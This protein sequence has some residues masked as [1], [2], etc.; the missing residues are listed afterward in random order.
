MPCTYLEHEC[1]RP[2][3][4]D[5]GQGVVTIIT[6]C[7]AIFQL[8][9]VE[10]T[11]T[12]LQPAIQVPWNCIRQSVLN[13]QATSSIAE[14]ISPIAVQVY[15]VV[16]N[17]D[18]LQPLGPCGEG[19]ATLYA[20][21]LDAAAPVQAWI[22]VWGSVA[23]TVV[24]KALPNTQIRVDRAVNWNFGSG[25]AAFAKVLYPGDPT[26]CTVPPIDTV[27]CGPCCPPATPQCPV[28]PT[29]CS[30]DDRL[31]SLV[32]CPQT[33]LPA[34]IQYCGCPEA[35]IR[36]HVRYPP[37]QLSAINGIDTLSRPA[38]SNGGS[39][40]LNCVP[41]GSMPAAS[42]NRRVGVIP[43]AFPVPPDAVSLVLQPAIP[44][45]NSDLLPANGDTLVI[46]LST[47]RCYTPTALPPGVVIDVVGPQ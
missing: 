36:T 35:P 6:G 20:V 21:P 40:D 2:R 41:D 47:I 10:A 39:C 19:G 11:T 42:Y 31:L 32:P 33:V 28:G 37:V 8:L 1:V 12:V 26:K 16:P 7:G 30:A 25:F 23:T 38:C 14:V 34:G 46:T 5:L 24:G 3:F 22:I 43:Y 17:S 29:A 18:E 13:L 27:T 9:N 44:F 15:R 4:Y 45:S